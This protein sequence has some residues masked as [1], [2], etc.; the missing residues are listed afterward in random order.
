MSARTRPQNADDYRVFV[1]PTLGDDVN[2]V[3]G[4]TVARMPATKRLPVSYV[5]IA[6][7]RLSDLAGSNAW[8]VTPEHG[9]KSK[10]TGKRPAIEVYPRFD[11]PGVRL[12]AAATS[13]A[14]KSTFVG[15]Y[16]A[17]FNEEVPLPTLL[18]SA[19]PED[20]ALDDKIEDLT[21]VTP[22]ALVEETAETGEISVEDFK[23]HIL[24][25]DDVDA[26]PN[27]GEKQLA[28]RIRDDALLTARHFNIPLVATTTHRLYAGA[29][30]LTPLLE[31]NQVVIFP[32]S[33]PVNLARLAEVYLGIARAE[34]PKI[35][36]LPTRAL[37]FN[38]SPPRYFI[39]GETV[40]LY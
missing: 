22:A 15:K 8:S 6:L 19:I 13:G 31:A 7:R 32:R 36:A 40:E 5:N 24:L 4:V 27:R 21:R 33:D 14:G 16:I 11:L 29:A 2:S 17:A 12:L 30:G 28:L 37:F 35:A 20:K 23:N 25:F 34:I 9:K 26:I 18:I 3:K 39:T 38:K 1:S 10:L